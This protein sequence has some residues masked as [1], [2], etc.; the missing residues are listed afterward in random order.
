MENILSLPAI[1]VRG[2][3]P[4][5]N[6]DLRIDVG[7]AVSLNALK[8]SEKEHDFNIIVLFQKNPLVEEVT[9]EDLY[10]V[11]TLARVTLKLKIPNNQL[12]VKLSLLKKVKI[13]K[14]TQ[15][16]PYFKVDYTLC[17][18]KEK[19]DTETVALVKLVVEELL[20]NPPLYLNNHD[21]VM[22]KIES[23][24]ASDQLCDIVSY[25]LRTAKD[26]A[27]Y[28]LEDS[29]NNR[30]TTVLSDLRNEKEIQDIENRINE[31]VK[32]S[33]DESQKEYYLREKMKAI[34]NELGDKAKKEED[35]DAMRERI[36][37]AEMPDAMMKKA[38]VELRRYQDTP[39]QSADSQ[40]LKNYLDFIIELP[41]VKESEDNQNLQQVIDVL[42]KN[43]YALDKVKDR[44]VEYLA[45]KI[46]TNKTPQTIL[47]LVG[48]PGVG[49][50]SLASSVAQALGRKFVKQS[51]GGVKDESEIRGHRRTYIGAL[52]G[53]ILK[54]MH[55]AKTINP[56]ILLDEIDKMASDIKGDPASA[57]LEVLDPEQNKQFSDHYMEEP[58]DLS[59]VLFITTA[60]Y[61]QNIPAPLRDRMEIVELS[62]Y[63]KFEKFNIAKNHL[64]KRQL[65]SHGITDKQF[66]IT[67]DGIMYIIDGYAPEAGVREL[68]RQIGA[69]VRKTIKDIL[70]KKV[71][72]VHMT[73]D[74]I[75]DYL[76]NPKYD[77]SRKDREDKVG[78]VTGLAYTAYGGST[79]DIEVTSYEGKGGIVLT[80]KLGD[81]MKESAQTALSYVKS[82]AK[83]FNIDPKFFSTHDIHVHVPEGATPK[84]G[85]S[86]GVTMTSAIVSALTNTKAKAS[87]GMTGEVT[88]VGTVL[89]IGGLREKAIAAQQTGIKTIL[90]PKDNVKDIEEIPTEVSSTLEIIPVSHIDE[91]LDLIL[92]K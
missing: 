66:S 42:N 41:W 18:E 23:G 79:L 64:I 75:K 39:S 31:A 69:L 45:V 67:D 8:V 14:V 65:D 38:L 34:Q 40:I 3:V 51:L 25:N 86:A 16:E 26:R 20:K 74:N 59:K 85:P 71:D 88:L 90:I 56:V 61:L 32:K 24:I 53:R 72:A 27:Y 22:K 7:R 21:D 12:R 52:P 11:G 62:S 43:H 84:D 19:D 78:V 15:E 73:V 58:Y 28:V 54:S 82:Q 9:A 36:A 5:P 4:I 60:N 33:V 57:M 89:P 13:E 47:C 48:P 91:V 29:L 17:E 81:V 68:N 83:K 70:I 63:T 80:G 35:I 77:N 92:V 1:A 49:K 6:N 46:M 50:T 2:S 87:I 76:G 30:L 10:E 55:D 44:I 37:Q